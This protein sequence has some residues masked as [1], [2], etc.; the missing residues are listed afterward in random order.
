MNI[1]TGLADPSNGQ[2]HA[3]IGR[4]Q[5][6]SLLAG[7]RVAG[8]WF[9]PEAV[10][11]VDSLTHLEMTST[12]AQARALGVTRAYQGVGIAETMTDFKALFDSLDL[13]LDSDAMTGLVEGW[14]ENN[15]HVQPHSCI[16]VQTGLATPLHFVN[17][18]REVTAGGGTNAR[19]MALGTIALQYHPD[20]HRFD[21]SLLAEI[22]HIAS[23]I[24][25]NSSCT[26]VANRH[27]LHFFMPNTPAHYSQASRCQASLD[28]L[29][30]GGLGPT[31][32][33]FSSV[34]ITEEEISRFTKNLQG[35]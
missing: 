18:V 34:P 13:A 16:D 2:F 22:G 31:T 1:D 35:K 7:W 6:A 26:Y 14:V 10:A 30:N 4:W 21:W 23:C 15:E 28:S 19:E 33:T 5:T 9:V 32:M 17:L 29:R 8:D 12:H 24:L 27:E 20:R 11:I 25:I 3:A